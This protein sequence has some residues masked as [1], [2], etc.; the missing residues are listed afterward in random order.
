MGPA[1]LG[2]GPPISGSAIAQCRGSSS[3]SPETLTECAPP[4]RWIVPV[5]AEL[6]GLCSHCVAAPFFSTSAGLAPA[7]TRPG[8]VCTLTPGPN[9]NA[10]GRVMATEIVT[11]SRRAMLAILSRRSCTAD[12]SLVYPNAAISDSAPIY[13]TARCQGFAPT[14]SCGR[15]SLRKR[16]VCSERG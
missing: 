2:R 5:S 16:N 7:I 6:P 1:P 10:K 15:H 14:T 9:L 13:R 12:R 11:T 4:G 3:S 8:G